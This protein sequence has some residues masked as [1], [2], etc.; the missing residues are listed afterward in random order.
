MSELV[1]NGIYFLLTKLNA[2]EDGLILVKSLNLSRFNMSSDCKLV[3]DMLN[4][5]V[6]EIRKIIRI[7]TFEGFYF[8]TKYY[9]SAHC[10]VKY[11]LKQ[12][13]FNSIHYFSK[14]FLRFFFK[15]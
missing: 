2:M 8:V 10:I 5:H 15:V 3:M 7:A 13:L 1:Y 6:K 12:N 9:N 14:R 11:I 4:N